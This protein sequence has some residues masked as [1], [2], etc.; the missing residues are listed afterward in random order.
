LFHHD[1]ADSRYG[2]TDTTLFAGHSLAVAGCGQPSAVRC[3]RT[4]AMSESSAAVLVMALI[5]F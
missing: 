4:R 2:G 5:A 3:E 1:I